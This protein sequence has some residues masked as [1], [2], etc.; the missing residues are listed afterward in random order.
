MDLF[1]KKAYMNVLSLFDGIS[2]G[3]L[4][5]NKLNINCTYY[6]SEIDTDAIKVTNN[7]FPNTIQ[8]GDINNWK[9][10]NI[11]NPDII[12]GGSPCQGFSFAG[13]ELNFSDPRSKLFF[14]FVDIIKHYKPQYF[15][16]EN[17]VMQKSFENIISNYLEVDPVKINSSL[18]SAQNR[19]R[20]YWANFKISEIQDR[21]ILF[22]DYI[23][24]VPA[25][26][27]GRRLNENGKRKDLDKTINLLQYIECRNDNKSNCISTVSKDTLVSELYV[28][29]EFYKNVN[30]RSLNS[31]ELEWLQTLP[32]GYTKIAKESTKHP[33]IGNGWTVDIIVEILKNIL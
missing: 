11:K 29:R 33:L 14:N 15:L 28:K 5:L 4:A 17:V 12:I 20:L 10:W 22:N 3:Q 25:R 9:T 24:G 1:I 32:I 6:A 19:Q 30:F 27:V 8:L 7:N 26:M 18:V 23:N 16:L 31:D 2:C 21:N 13:K